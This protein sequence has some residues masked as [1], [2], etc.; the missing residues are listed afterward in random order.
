RHEEH[1]EK[2]LKSLPWRFNASGVN[3]LDNLQILYISVNVFIVVYHLCYLVSQ[4]SNI[5]FTLP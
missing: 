2:N 3:F 5:F 1:E 4:L